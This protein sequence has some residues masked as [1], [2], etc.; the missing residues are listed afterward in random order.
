M[1]C[2]L[3]PATSMTGGFAVAI[4]VT[5]LTK[6]ID[7][8]SVVTVPLD[9]VEL[10]PEPPPTA[11]TGAAKAARSATAD[12]ALDQGLRNRAEAVAGARRAVEGDSRSMALCQARVWPGGNGVRC[13]WVTV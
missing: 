3:P 1:T 5:R 10:Q 9:W 11:T 4:V 2:P 7:E 6:M 12:V 13:Q 8:T